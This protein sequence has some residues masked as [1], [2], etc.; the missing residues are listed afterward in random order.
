MPS[1]KWFGVEMLADVFL[2]V[3]NRNVVV[4]S[5]EISSSWGVFSHGVDCGMTR[6]TMTSLT[7]RERPA[8]HKMIEFCA[9]TWVSSHMSHCRH[10][11][12][13]AALSFLKLLKCKPWLIN[14]ANIARS[15]SDDRVHRASGER[16]CLRHR[17]WR[18]IGRKRRDGSRKR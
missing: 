9:S 13:S 4:M 16:R 3:R 5:F 2:A 8:R 18:P 15:S 14:T 1:L 6:R 10:Y 12:Q 11:D 17:R 7:Q